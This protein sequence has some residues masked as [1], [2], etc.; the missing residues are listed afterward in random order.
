MVKVPE[1]ST[2]LPGKTD[3]L[4]VQAPGIFLKASKRRTA[5]G[6]KIRVSNKVTRDMNGM[7]GWDLD[8]YGWDILGI[9]WD[10]NGILWDIH[11]MDEY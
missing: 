7:Y 10:I 6:T 2:S 1:G 3:Y 5:S 11:I 8:A 4:Q 9:I